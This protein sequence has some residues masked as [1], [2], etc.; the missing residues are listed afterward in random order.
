MQNFPQGEKKEWLFKKIK[1]KKE[2]YYI[3]AEFT[4]SNIRANF[5]SSV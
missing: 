1:F 3:S 2:R 4:Y 5:Y